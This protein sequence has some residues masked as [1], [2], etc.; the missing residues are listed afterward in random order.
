MRVET[1]A[2][3]A[4][5]TGARHA[6]AACAGPLAAGL[7]SDA[8]GCGSVMAPSLRST[9]RRRTD[10]GR[11]ASHSPSRMSQTVGIGGGR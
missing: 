2:A 10:P 5:M 7:G 6:E 1:P 4:I 11:G 9:G 8:G 3:G